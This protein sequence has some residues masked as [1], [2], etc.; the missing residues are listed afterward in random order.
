MRKSELKLQKKISNPV[1]SFLFGSKYLL[2]GKAGIV[3]LSL[4]NIFSGLQNKGENSA[5]KNKYC[6]L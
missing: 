6:Y 1:I 3:S 2:I 4:F 5:G